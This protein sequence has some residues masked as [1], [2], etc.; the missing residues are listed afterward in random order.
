VSIKIG[1]NPDLPRNDLEF[2]ISHFTLLG[3]PRYEKN[4]KKAYFGIF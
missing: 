3:S 4:K 1:Y 2:K